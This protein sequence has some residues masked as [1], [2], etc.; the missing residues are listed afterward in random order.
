M[1]LWYNSRTFQ[2]FLIHITR[3]LVLFPHSI[4]LARIDLYYVPVRDS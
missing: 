3:C 2:M 1:R 4:I